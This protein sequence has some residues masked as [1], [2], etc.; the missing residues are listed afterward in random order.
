IHDVCSAIHP[1]AAAS[2]F[3]KSL[4]LESHGLEL[5]YPE[6]SAAH[7]YDNGKAAFF[8]ISLEETASALRRDKDAYLK[9]MEPIVKYWPKIDKDVL[10]PMLRIPDAPIPLAKFGLKAMTSALMLAKRFTTQEARGLWAGMAA[11]SIQ[12]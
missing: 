3:F 8:T 9:L 7:P 11:H 5:I 10:G 6:I 1:M 2:P 4:P 12:P